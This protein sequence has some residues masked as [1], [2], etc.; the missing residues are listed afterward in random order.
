MAATIVT[1]RGSVGGG[2]RADCAGPTEGEQCRTRQR[3]E[4]DRDFW[5]TPQIHGF[6]SINLP[7]EKQ[8]G[9]L[10]QIKNIEDHLLI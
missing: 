8:W 4:C 10:R 3:L 6:F 9:K 2:G 1:P 5:K 7:N